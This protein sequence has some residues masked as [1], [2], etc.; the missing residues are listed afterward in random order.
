MEHRA[1]FQESEIIMKTEEEIIKMTEEEY[2]KF[3]CETFPSQF[4]DRNKPMTETCMYW[5]FCI[6]PGWRY[7][8][9]QVC[10]Q[11]DLIEKTFGIG[12]KWSQIKEKFGTARFYYNFVTKENFE[13]SAQN[14]IVI[15]IIEDL[16]SKA[17]NETFHT[18]E[19]TGKYFYDQIVIGHW[20]YGMSEEGFLKTYPERKDSLEKFKKMK[21]LQHKANY[22]INKMDETQLEKFIEIEKEKYP[23]NKNNYA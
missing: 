20:V 5:G 15:A 12:I 18:C 8:L 7:I 13:S 23:D 1:P 10:N 6:G 17:E 14:N 22:F 3:M 9:Y 19:I 2:D 4:I 16:I 21:E 11:L